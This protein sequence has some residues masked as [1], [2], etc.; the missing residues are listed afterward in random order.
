MHEV[1]G[2]RPSLDPPVVVASFYEDPTPILPLRTK[3]LRHGMPH[4]SLNLPKNLKNNDILDFLAEESS[5]EQR[6][7]K[8]S[9]TKT[10]GFGPL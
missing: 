2:A 6:R 3:H 1:L 5:K 8:E 7:H 4:N 9:E 10:I